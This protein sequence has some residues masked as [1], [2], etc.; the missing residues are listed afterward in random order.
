V[1]RVG[2]R[3]VVDERLASLVRFAAHNLAAP[4]LPI[5]TPAA[6]DL[7]VCRNV[8]IYLEDWARRRVM[9]R[10]CAALADGGWLI[11]GA[12]DPIPAADLHVEPVPG[13]A[14][15]YRRRTKTVQDVRW[16]P[17]RA[18]PSEDL[19]PRAANASVAGLEPNGT[20]ALARRLGRGA[21]ER[22]LEQALAR[23]PESAELR[24]L[25]G[26]LLLDRGRL[27]AARDALL[28]ATLLDAELAVAHFALGTVLLQLGDPARASRSFAAAAAIAARHPGRAAVPLGDGERWAELLDA[29][30][31]QAALA[32]R[33]AS[34]QP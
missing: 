17:R 8:L 12:T 30:R 22:E 19:V 5:G 10:L 7:V 15:I 21:G 18:A 26:L 4:E 34:V 33:R 6:V 20:K 31:R 1:H 29:A 2:D 11:L 3:F 32:V 28:R 16:R 25:H 14:G 24:A 9:E 27:A 13:V 23:Q